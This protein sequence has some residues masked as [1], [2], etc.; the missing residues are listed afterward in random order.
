MKLLPTK[1]LLLIPLILCGCGDSEL[2]APY[3]CEEE[4]QNFFKIRTETVI[5]QQEK[6]KKEITKKL[7]ELAQDADEP[8]REELE[9]ALVNVER[10]LKSPEFF[11]FASMD[12]LP[13]DLEWV[14]NWE[15]PDI[16]SVLAPLAG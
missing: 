5:K 8:K 6:K 16:G 2:Y 4:K 3:D 15:S 1:L 10:R 12:D 7:A 14:T 13:A 11:T 9:E